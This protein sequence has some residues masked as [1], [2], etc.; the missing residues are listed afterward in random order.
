MQILKMMIAGT[1]IVFLTAQTPVPEETCGTDVP[2]REAEVKAVACPDGFE[3]QWF[4]ERLAGSC[5][6]YP[7]NPQWFACTQIIEPKG[8]A[9]D[10]VEAPTP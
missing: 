4:Q 6:W 5:D 7:H 3:G 1:A 2:K 9:P 10:P 8:E